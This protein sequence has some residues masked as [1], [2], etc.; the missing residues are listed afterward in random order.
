MKNLHKIIIPQWNLQSG[1][2]LTDVVLS[3]QFFGPVLGTAPV[4]L[5][6]HALTG[7]SNVGGY[8]GWWK[9]LIGEDKTIDT[10][11]FFTVIAFNIPGNG[12]DDDADNLIHNYKDFTAKDV[13][14]VFWQ[15]LKQLGVSQLHTI[16]GGSLGG[17]I[18]WEMAA[19]EPKKV[20]NLIPVAT[21][22]KATD[23]VIANTLVQDRV[24]NNSVNPVADARL[25]AMLLYRTP[26]SLQQRF[27]RVHENEAFAI[28]NWLNRHG[29]ILA[30]RFALPSYKL[31][32]Q[33]L[34]TIDIAKGTSFKAVAKTITAAIH[35]VAVDSDLLFTADET[36]KTYKL[37]KQ[38]GNEVYYHEIQSVHGHDAFLIEWEQLANILA[39]VF[40]LD[41]VLEKFH[42]DSQR[43]RKETQSIKAEVYNMFK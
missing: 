42:K 12:F 21:D 31:M 23:W 40:R 2:Q 41:E 15:G 18:A 16:I 37:L 20:A 17:G 26:Q 24:L 38:N 1:T 36:L 32:N 29:D 33:L 39:P 43:R 6:N 19:I 25:H 10:N 14:Q 35:L 9:T 8:N 4:V 27:N 28:E 5:V 30:E 34:K 7:N 22:W 13:A 11:Y 3:Y